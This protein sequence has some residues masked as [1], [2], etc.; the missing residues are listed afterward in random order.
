[1]LSFPIEEKFSVDRGIGFAE[2]SGPERQP[3]L[4]CAERCLEP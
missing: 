2:K 3:E 1:M 4:D